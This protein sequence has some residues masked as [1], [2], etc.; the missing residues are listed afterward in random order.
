MRSS[1]REKI[2]F[3]IQDHWKLWKIP[4]ERRREDDFP[5]L[6][7]HSSHSTAQ[8]KLPNISA[9]KDPF[10]VRNKDKVYVEDQGA[11]KMFGQK[12]AEVHWSLC[13][14][15]SCFEALNITNISTTRGNNAPQK[16]G[17]LISQAIA[18]PWKTSPRSVSLVSSKMVSTT[19]WNLEKIICGSELSPT[20]EP[21][22]TA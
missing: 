19:T 18:L 15:W 22:T 11:C 8:K 9:V 17:K 12:D 1:G 13:S 16:E 6:V 5:T 14:A 2:C 7:T 10:K 20:T 3:F 21:S 4:G